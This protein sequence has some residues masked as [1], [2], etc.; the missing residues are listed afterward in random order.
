MKLGVCFWNFVLKKK[1]YLIIIL[2]FVYTDSESY[3][4]LVLVPF[5]T[6]TSTF[7]LVIFGK[8][9]ENKYN[10]HEKLFG[11]NFE[12]LVPPIVDKMNTRNIIS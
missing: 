11:V 5:T 3:G 1:V 6:K 9:S 12:L 7:L 4:W 10:C 2:N 8:T